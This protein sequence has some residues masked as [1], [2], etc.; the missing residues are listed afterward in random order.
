[1]LLDLSGRVVDANDASLAAVLA[2]KKDV[3]GQRFGESLWFATTDGIG[4]LIDRAVGAAVQGRSSLHSLELE[5]P[6]GPRSF[7]F[8]FRPLLDAEGVV[9]AVVSE[10][11]ERR[12]ASRPNMHCANH[13]R[14][15]RSASSPAASRMIQQHP[16]GHL[17]QRRARHAAE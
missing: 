7:D 9:T 12:R 17:R 10:A 5:L 16:D 13:R 6:T 2:E 11:V 3:L 4:A 15:R 14:S 1:M 8:S